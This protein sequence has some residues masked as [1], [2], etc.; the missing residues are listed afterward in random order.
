MSEQNIYDNNEFFKEY[1]KL[2]QNVDSANNLEEKPAIFAMI[3]DVGGKSILDLG[4]GYGENCRAFSE[5][6]A[7]SVTGIDISKKMLE[8]AAKENGAP[9]VTYLN[10]PMEEISGLTQK[11]DLVVSSLA[12]HYVQDYA[13]L[14]GRV[15]SLLNDGGVFVFSQEHPLTTA[16]TG[17]AEWV[18]NAG[19]EIDHY[20]LTDY[21]RTGE[22][23]VTW[24]I[25]GVIK[26]HRTFSE[27][28]NGLAAA[29]F[30]VEEVREPVPSPEEMRRLPRLKKELHKP[31]FLIIKVRK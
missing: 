26:Y 8:I 5:I 29:G 23:S 13:G 11:F 9:N 27:L 20:R 10:M 7:K 15:Y 28:F 21:M 17:G 19:G 30:R 22:R 16:P 25:D 3:G 18:R 6:G 31:N 4:C 1:F 2:R 24:L 12:I 14:V